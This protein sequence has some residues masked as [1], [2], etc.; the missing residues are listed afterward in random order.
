MTLERA[1]TNNDIGGRL[2]RA[3][4]QRGLSLRDTANA[5]KLS[6]AV[7]QAI[8]GND[9]ARLPGGMFRKAY[10]RTLAGVVGLDPDEMAADYCARFEPPSDPST[11]P[12]Q[13]AALHAAL[14]RQVK[15][16]R[17]PSLVTLAV[18][19]VSA[20][21]WFMLQAAPVPPRP[22][23]DA[24]TELVAVPMPRSVSMILA[25][26]SSPDPTP[27]AI[28]ARTSEVPLRVELAASGWCW[29]AAEAD[30]ARLLYRLV[31]PGERVVLEGERLISL[32]LGDAG[33][34]TLS[35][36]GGA[37][38]TLGSD[39]EVV[40]LEVT[41]DNVEGLRDVAVETAS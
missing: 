18:L 26:D 8:E 19:A 5:T 21:A 16:S 34:V 27:R 25:A 38:R 23:L 10:V 24:A 12:A 30:G 32:R 39:G 41:P 1:V 14:L 37:S 3:R 7:I 29:V 17:R 15:P 40:E 35:I 6:I 36:N 28:T 31:E 4:D 11:V 33:S 9:F 2:R 20:S 13:D 22:L